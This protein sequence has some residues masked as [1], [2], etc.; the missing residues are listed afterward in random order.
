M[1][2]LLAELLVT[3]SILQLVSLLKLKHLVLHPA[4]LLSNS[5]TMVGVDL[6][7]QLMVLIVQVVPMLHKTTLIC[8]IWSKVLKMTSSLSHS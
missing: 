3:V 8:A 1:K 4:W 5:L 6:A 7:V 2:V